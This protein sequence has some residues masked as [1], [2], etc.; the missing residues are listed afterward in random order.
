MNNI[1]LILLVSLI[2][3]TPSYS[4]CQE[5]RIDTGQI[6]KAM[7]RIIIPANWNHNL[8]LYAHGY[9]PPSMPGSPKMFH[10]SMNDNGVKAFTDRGFAVARSAYRKNGWALAEGVD[11]TEAL[12]KFFFKKYGKPDTYFITG[13][14]MGGGITFA[15]IE[16]FGKYYHGALPMCP[17]AARPY[18]QTKMGFDMNAVFAAMFPGVLPP[19]A[20]VTTGKAP[21]FPMTEVQSAIKKD[22]VLAAAIA[23]R[24]ELKPKDLAFVIM[25][26]DG[27][28][29]D[30]SSQAGGNPF[31]NTNTLY[32]GFP[33]D[34]EVNCRV[35][36][37]AATPGTEDFFDKYDRTG[38]INC[39]TLIIHTIYDQLI[40]PSMAVGLID[41]MVRQQGK[42]QNLVVMYTNG[43]R[44]CS[45]TQDE[46]GRAFDLLRKWV[47]KNIRPTPGMLPDYPQNV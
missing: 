46:T 2:L 42:Q 33:N 34:W 11:D 14:S 13:N 35:E 22:T 9:V 40:I 43:Q 5:A 1:K 44:H 41:E 10:S 31:D 17:L 37:L 30:V 29:R 38:K 23:R 32:S 6:N 36:R 7:Y 12:R 28:I 19:L 20:D 16:N 4:F 24:Y 39:P 25:F 27:M 26:N 8:V 45:F 18:L 3:I 47:G 21:A 15:T